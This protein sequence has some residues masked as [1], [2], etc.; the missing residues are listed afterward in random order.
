ML[1][2]GPPPVLEQMARATGTDVVGYLTEAPGF[3]AFVLEDGAWRFDGPIGILR[4]WG[5]IIP[6]ADAPDLQ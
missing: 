6:M 2:A 1:E 5:Q 3:S 4:P